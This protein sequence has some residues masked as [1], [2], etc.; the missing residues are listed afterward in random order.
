MPGRTALITGIA[1]QDGSYL[2]ELLIA[3]DYRVIGLA[4]P[5]NSDMSRISHLGDQVRVEQANLLD[6]PRLAEL[7]REIKPNEVYNLAGLS[8]VPSSWDR[9]HLKGDATG[10]GAVRLLEAIRVTLQATPI[11]HEN[12]HLPVI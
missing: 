2:S 4:R 3:R 10:L 11:P 6:V 8:F 7:L 12:T 1:G 5:G 9:P